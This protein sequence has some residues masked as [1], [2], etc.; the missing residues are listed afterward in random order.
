MQCAS[1][2]AEFSAWCCFSPSSTPYICIC[3][4]NLL[5]SGVLH[6]WRSYVYQKI[7]TLKCLKVIIPQLLNAVIFPNY[8]TVSVDLRGRKE[9]MEQL[10]GKQHRD[11]RFLTIGTER[12][13]SWISLSQIL[14]Y[15]VL[16][17]CKTNAFSAI[18]NIYT[19]LTSLFSVAK[20][21]MALVVVGKGQWRLC[22]KCHF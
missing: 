2:S 17:V 12:S 1:Q 15:S 4:I 19:S 6:L 9:L 5:Q 11:V 18:F 10:A 21:T 16:T 13:C 22:V 14:G 3:G 8:S 20:S 7:K